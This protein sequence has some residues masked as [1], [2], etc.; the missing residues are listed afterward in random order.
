M[1]ICKG[2]FARLY[3]VLTSHQQT[4]LIMHLSPCRWLADCSIDRCDGFID[5]NAATR[6]PR[7]S[8]ASEMVDRRPSCARRWQ[9]STLVIGSIYRP[10]SLSAPIHFHRFFVFFAFIGCC[11]NVILFFGLRCLFFSTFATLAA[12]CRWNERLLR[13]SASAGLADMVSLQFS[14][15]TL[16]RHIKQTRQ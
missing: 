9:S 16:P 8:H 11:L 5:H 1:V 10:S 15:Q 13:P 12:F 4:R 2:N 7:P 6:A 3:S 14:I